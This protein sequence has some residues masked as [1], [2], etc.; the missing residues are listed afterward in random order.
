M[1]IQC[2][3]RLRLLVSG[4]VADFVL[5]SVGYRPLRMSLSSGVSDAWV[6]VLHS[7]KVSHTGVMFRWSHCLAREEIHA[8]V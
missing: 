7:G 5:R 2:T 6:C 3:C 1:C 4:E 8:V